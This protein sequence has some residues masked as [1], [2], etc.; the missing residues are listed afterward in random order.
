[1][2]LT[3]VSDAVQ[4]RNI[5]MRSAKVLSVAYTTVIGDIAG[6]NSKQDLVTAIVAETC[7]AMA[8][9]AQQFD[10]QWTM[11]DIWAA[12]A[13]VRASIEEQLMPF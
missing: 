9:M 7:A 1:M 5:V 12:E 4:K 6:N 8:S 13:E 2:E 10:L 11:E 3:R